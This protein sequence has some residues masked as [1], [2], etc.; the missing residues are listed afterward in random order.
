MQECTTR[1]KYLKQ[2]AII[3]RRYPEAADYLDALPHARVY[4][5]AILQ[6]G[7]TTH[8][9]K[10]SNCVEILN[11]VIEDARHDDV[12]HFLDWVMQWFARKLGERQRLAAKYVAEKRIFTR[13]AGE[14]YGR[15]ERMAQ[16]ENLTAEDLGAGKHLVKHIKKGDTVATRYEVDLK[17]RTCTC[18]F[19][20][21]FR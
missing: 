6:A 9:H 16:H 11:N 3:R 10:T 19:Q 13:Y 15:S 18:T 7:L 17:E 20:C 21:Q 5:Y 2:L 14:L 12:I 4:H 1:A 8:G